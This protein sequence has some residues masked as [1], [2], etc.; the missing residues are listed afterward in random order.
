MEVSSHA[1]VMGRVDGVVFDVAVFPNLGRDHLDFHADLEDYFAGEGRAV[2]PR[3]GPASALVNVDDEHGRRLAAEAHHPDAHLLAARRA[4]P[5]G[6]PSTSPRRRPARRF[7][8]LG[9]DGDPRARRLS[10]ARGVQRRQRARRDR[11]GRRRP[12]S[13]PRT[14]AAGIAAGG[15]C[16]RP[17]GAGRRRPGLRRRRRLRPQARRASRP[18]LATLR[19]LTDGQLIV[20]I[21]AGGDRD[22]GKRPVMGEIAARLA[23]VV[24]V[25][26]DNPRTEDPAAIR[27]AVLGG[28]PGRAGR[29]ARGR[30]TGGAAIRE[31]VGRAPARRRRAGRRQGPRDRPGGRRRACTPST[32]AR[33]S[34][35]GVWPD[36][37]DRDDPRRDRRGRRRGGRTGDGRPGRRGGAF[38][39]SRDAG[40]RADSSSRSPAS[41]STATT[42]PP[43][44]V[45]AGAVAV[46]G[47]RPTGVPTVRRGRRG[48]GARPARPRTCVDRLPDLTVLAMTG[49]QGKT[50]TK[51]Y[52][53]HVLAD[54]RARRSRPRGNLNNELGVPAD[55]AAARRADTAL[56]RRRDGRPRRSATSPT[57]ARSRRPR[58]AAVLNVGTAHLGEFGVREAI[59]RGQGRD[60]RGAARRRHRGAQRRRRPAS[61]RW[62][63]RTP[64]RRADLRRGRADVAVGDDRPPTTSG[65]PSFE[66]GYRGSG[67]HRCASPRSAP[68]RWRNAAAAAAMA[69]AAGL[70]LDAVADAL[71]RRRARLAAGGWSCTSAPTAWSS[72]TTPTTP[73]PSRCAPPSTRCAA[74]GARRGR[75][76]VARPRRDARARRRRR[77]RPTARSARLR[78][79]ARRRRAWSPSAPRRPGSPTGADAVRAGGWPSP[80]RGVT[81]P[82]TGCGTM[83]RRRTSSS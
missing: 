49:S 57:S 45:A 77:T 48:R 46:L 8:V 21:G 27:A 65:R 59:A 68:T 47:S 81:R 14:V 78:R 39:D 32:T 50:G 53:A 15:G 3:A 67:G 64:A 18:L 35:R 36:P 73:T 61:P 31:A 2:H 41:T 7:T 79:R 40:A 12:G 5:T 25:T 22:T 55:R 34:R 56:P 26:D 51:D 9:P 10:A 42:S 17:A 20:V 63:S 76:T 71:G 38:L 29:G 69:L 72:S 70:D 19:P 37:D 6:A 74:I 16:A 58:V 24:V 23:D 62:P 13:T 80:R 43:G 60:R 1:L 33:S 83:S 30:A 11:R 28:R 66:L 75:R 4:T 52:L 82:S 54:G 44:A